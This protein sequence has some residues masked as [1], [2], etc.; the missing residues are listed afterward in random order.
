MSPIVLYSYSS[1]FLL[2][3]QTEKLSLHRQNV[4]YQ[5]CVLRST[6]HNSERANHLKNYNI[7]FISPQY[8]PIYIDKKHDIE[9]RHALFVG[10][11]NK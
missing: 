11:K 9:I 3:S 7:Y 6:E 10:R 5:L 8:G 2:C 4:S 1:F